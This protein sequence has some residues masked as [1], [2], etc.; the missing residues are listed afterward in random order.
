M[1]IIAAPEIENEKRDRG[2][3]YI[4]LPWLLRQA[5]ACEEVKLEQEQLVQ[6]PPPPPPLDEE[7]NSYSSSANMLPP[8]PEPFI[9]LQAWLG[10]LGSAPPAYTDVLDTPSAW[11][12]AHNPLAA[13]CIC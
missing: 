10:W 12:T 13:S 5:N 6:P 8:P 1:H 11:L 4:D 3:Q 9:V 2:C 7:P